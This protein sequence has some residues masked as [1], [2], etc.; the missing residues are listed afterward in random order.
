MHPVMTDDREYRSFDR[1]IAKVRTAYAKWSS[2]QREGEAAH[3]ARERAYREDL[4]RSMLEGDECRLRDPGP[5]IPPKGDPALFLRREIELDAARGKWAARRGERIEAAAAAAEAELMAEA[6]EI[7]GRL[8][9]LSSELEQLR[10]T[11]EW[12]RHRRDAAPPVGPR[13]RPDAVLDAAKG[14]YSVVFGTAGPNA[15]V[16]FN[17]DGVDVA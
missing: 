16:P 14:G 8:D 13:P 17:M 6:R 4:E 15:T 3:R 1:E 7:A 2:K 11:V 5:W 12:L 9:A 10:E